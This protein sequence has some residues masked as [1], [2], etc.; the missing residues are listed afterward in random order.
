MWDGPRRRLFCARD[1]LGVKPLFY[2]QIGQTIVISNTLDCIRLHPAV[3]RDLNDSAIA[4]FLLFGA[5]QQI[6]TTV[7]P[8]H[9]AAASGPLHHV[10]EGHDAVPPLLDAAGG[11]ADP[12]QTRRRVLGPV[13]GAAASCAAR[14][15]AN[16]PRRR[17][18]ERWAGFADARGCGARVVL[19]ERSTGF[20]LQAITS[21]Y[22]RL[23]P[24]IERHYRR[25][26][27][28]ASEHSHSV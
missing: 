3:S 12:F 21:V 25:S 6:D 7:V 22:D 4:D 19:R 18:D 17:V 15:A 16:T 2:A 26:G 11:R 5:N 27:C 20:F 13:H 1:H 24:D 23:I 8:R 10:V 14:S 28:G 9:P